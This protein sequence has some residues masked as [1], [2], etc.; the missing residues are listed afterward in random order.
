LGLN[1]KQNFVF[2]NYFWT[3]FTEVVKNEKMIVIGSKGNKR[4]KT[5]TSPI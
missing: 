2:E 3:G 5:N 1:F 4:S